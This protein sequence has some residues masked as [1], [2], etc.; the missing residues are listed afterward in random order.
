MTTKFKKRLKRTGIVFAIVLFLI[1]RLFSAFVL[2]E[3][4]LGD[5][6]ASWY[7]G[8]RNKKI[9]NPRFLE[10]VQKYAFDIKN[11]TNLTDFSDLRFLDTIFSAKQIIGV[12][13]ATHGS[14]EFFNM[15]H[16]LFTYLVTKHN[17][18]LFGIEADFAAC[19]KINEYVTTG[20]GNA[21]EALTN[22]GYQV[23]NTAEVLQLIEWMRQYNLEK[24]DSAKVQFWG[25][26]MQQAHSS[27]RY[28]RTYFQK[29][30]IQFDERLFI[31]DINKLIKEVKKKESD[32]TIKAWQ[33][34]ANEL[35][36]FMKTNRGNLI[37]TTSISEYELCLQMT[38]NIKSCFTKMAL[39]EFG[40][41]FSYRDSC[42]ANNVRWIINHNN[43]KKIMLWAHNGHIANDEW[44]QTN[45]NKPSKW[46]GKFL[47]EKYGDSYYTIAFLFNEGSFTAHIGAKNNLSLL[48]SFIKSV[49][50]DEPWKI[51]STYIGPYRKNHLSNAMTK[52]GKPLFFLH[53]KN[54][55]SSCILAKELNK[56]NNYYIVGAVYV[57]KPTSIIEQNF[58]KTFDS[59]I[60]VDK[61]HAAAHFGIGTFGD[62]DN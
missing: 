12:G 59:L 28:I 22:N 27:Y 3:P 54:I 4:F 57:S 5:T 10:D 20:R 17:Y 7:D 50:A 14:K 60:Y 32:N 23:W 6:I 29:S 2:G 62:I 39:K 19:Q 41:S 55:D 1:V 8:E 38:A 34:K 58:W 35:E 56:L 51:D 36:E 16:R 42:M 53:F 11:T 43:N 44:D 48:F 46:M 18:K 61:V 30:D 26:D 40:I 33:I 47:K 21:K 25:Y 9:T 31:L 45:G 15:K 52:T 49:F 24:P 13:E 37:K